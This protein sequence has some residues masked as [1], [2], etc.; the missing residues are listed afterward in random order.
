MIANNLFPKTPTH[1][2][3]FL[4]EELECR[5]VSE[6]SFA[7]RIGLEENFL[8]DLLNGKRDF[9]IESAMLIE[10]GLGIDSDYWIN[11][12]TNYD[13]AKAANN[14]SFMERLASIRKIA[15]AL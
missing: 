3:V 9:T 10:A 5:G 12:Q 13:K 4:R 8:K 6:E 1:P 15:A 11:L 14:P 2:G 7:K